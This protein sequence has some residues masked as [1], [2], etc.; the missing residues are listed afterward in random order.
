MS[1]I[2][3]S[4][5]NQS[6]IGSLLCGVYYYCLSRTNAMSDDSAVIGFCD[7]IE[8][9]A[10]NPF[11]KDISFSSIKGL[12]ATVS[13]ASQKPITALSSLIALVRDKQ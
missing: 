1:V 11:T 9:V 3:G 4:D 2:N 5:Y 7:A 12:N 10:F 6:N 8:T 13:I